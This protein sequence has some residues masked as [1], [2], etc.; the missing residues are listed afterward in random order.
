VSH[1][2]DDLPNEFRDVDARMRELR[3]EWTPVELDRIKLRA[4]ESGRKETTATM[5]NRVTRKLVALTLAATVGIGGVAVAAGDHG[6]GTKPGK[7]CG[8]KNHYHEQR[9]S[10]K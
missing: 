4:M 3:D 7:G 2:Y 8:D 1:S 6:G 5:V 10:C 9:A